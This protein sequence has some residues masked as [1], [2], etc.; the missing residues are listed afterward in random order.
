MTEIVH[1]NLN[2]FVK[3]KRALYARGMTTR[4]MATTFKEMYGAEVS[5]RLISRVTEAVIDEVNAWQNHPL[6]TVY[7]RLYLDCIVIKCHQDKRVINKSI[8]LVNLM[9]TVL[10]KII[11]SEKINLKLYPSRV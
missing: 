11:A 6:E 4:D 3:G 7:P 9:Q 1:S 2:L 10:L 8:Y 5:H